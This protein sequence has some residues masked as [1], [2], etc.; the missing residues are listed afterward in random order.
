M[1]YISH[2]FLICLSSVL[3][4]YSILSKVDEVGYWNNRLARDLDKFAKDMGPWGEKI[5]IQT[6]GMVGNTFDLHSGSF[7]A[8][9]ACLAFVLNSVK[10]SCRRFSHN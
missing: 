8:K 6:E 4:F 3:T 9:L 5:F 1:G 10:T 2:T 7:N